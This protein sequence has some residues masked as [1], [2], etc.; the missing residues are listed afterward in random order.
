MH[1]ATARLL[2]YNGETGRNLSTRLT[3]HKRA[4]RRDVNNHIAELHLQTKPIN[5]TGTLRHVLRIL[6]TTISMAHFIFALLT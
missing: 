1:A 6:Q 3:E 2:A 4:T 5:S